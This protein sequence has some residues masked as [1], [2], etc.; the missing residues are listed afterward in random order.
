[1]T[2]TSLNPALEAAKRGEPVRPANPFA[3]PDTAKKPIPPVSPG[4]LGSIGSA[5]LEALEPAVANIERLC[6]EAEDPQT[7][8]DACRTLLDLARRKTPARLVQSAKLAVP[9]AVASLATLASTSG[10][11]V[12]VAATNALLDVLTRGVD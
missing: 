2:D 11:S 12:A 7:K 9:V 10:S 5:A 6:H 4:R 8:L 3:A 1:M